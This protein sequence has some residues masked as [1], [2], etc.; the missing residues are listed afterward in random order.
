MRSKEDN[1]L[2]QR[3]SVFRKEANASIFHIPSV[4]H[5]LGIGPKTHSEILMGIVVTYM[6]IAVCVVML[7]VLG[8]KE[9]IVLEQRPKSVLGK[10]PMPLY[11]TYPR[12]L[13]C[14]VLD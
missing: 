12:S 6:I 2:E 7:N 8:T 4:T 9:D 1:G 11:F 14:L 5:L 3:Q 13:S 10:M